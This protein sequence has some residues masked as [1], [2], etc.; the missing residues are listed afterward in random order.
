MVNGQLYFNGSYLRAGE[1]DADVVKIINLSASDIDTGIIHSA[2]YETVVIPKVYPAA[3]LYPAANVYPN[4]GERVIRGFAIDFATGQIYGAFYSEQIEDLQ[5]AQ[6]DM[7]GD[8][9]DLQTTVSGMGTNVSQLQTA[10][11]NL[12]STVSNLQDAITALQNALVYPKALPT[13]M[14]MFPARNVE[15]PEEI[16]DNAGE[17]TT[18]GEEREATDDVNTGDKMQEATDDKTEEER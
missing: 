1:I 17:D 14:A 8:I 11:S 5:D 9:G 6:D 2:D 12:Q 15:E 4:N 18:D 10:V 3:D 7:S 13:R 16:T